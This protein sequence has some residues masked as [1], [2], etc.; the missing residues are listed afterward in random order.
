MSDEPRLVRASE[1]YEMEQAK[2]AFRLHFRTDA[3]VA[4]QVT[5]GGSVLIE[6]DIAHIAALIDVNRKTAFGN[7]AKA[8]YNL[9]A[10]LRASAAVRDAYPDEPLVIAFSDDDHWPCVIRPK[11]GG[12]G[13]AVA[14]ITP[15]DFPEDDDLQA[16][17]LHPQ[18]A[19]VPLS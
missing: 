3:H 6:Q 13:I 7:G 17:I 8:V 15:R 4:R 18:A 10:L 16:G 1:T 12:Y 11:T 2:G 14:P 9:D 19:G 5:A